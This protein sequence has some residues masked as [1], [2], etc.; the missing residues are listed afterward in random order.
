MLA[1]MKATEAIESD[2]M[3]VLF[4]LLRFIVNYGYIK[5]NVAKH[6]SI[7]IV[8]SMWMWT[9]YW[10]VLQSSWDDIFFTNVRTAVD[11]VISFS[12]A[13][14]TMSEEIDDTAAP[15]VK[16][17]HDPILLFACLHLFCWSIFMW[18]RGAPHSIRP[19][20]LARSPSQSP[21]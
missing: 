8:V 5:W 18:P 14:P 21:T 4:I 15:A 1:R 13:P 3:K 7:N 12:F 2:V 9:K 16:E 11:A 10:D 6:L 20:W 19:P 17:C